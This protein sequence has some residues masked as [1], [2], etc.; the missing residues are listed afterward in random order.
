MQ[1]RPIYS[2]IWRDGA[3]AQCE[4]AMLGSFHPQYLRPSKLITIIYWGIEGV[5]SGL[6]ILDLSNPEFPTLI[7]AWEDRETPPA[8]GIHSAALQTV[9][10]RGIAVR[11][12][13][14]YLA[15]LSREAGPGSP[16]EFRV[17][18]FFQGNSQPQMRSFPVTLAEDWDEAEVYD[19]CTILGRILLRQY[20]SS[21]DSEHSDDADYPE[22]AVMDFV[23]PRS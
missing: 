11:C 14:R 9:D 19:T 13:R 10:V 8:Y 1:R 17:R 23:F 21:S 6:R 22:L 2:L 3:R 7:S 18:A 4:C 5:S 20:D 16:L 15:R 12:G